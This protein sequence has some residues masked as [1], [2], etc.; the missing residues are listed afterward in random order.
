MNQGEELRF[1]RS[2]GINS[3]S[4]ALNITGTSEVFSDVLGINSDSLVDLSNEDTKIIGVES[5]EVQRGNVKLNG[6]QWNT[7]N[8][9]KAKGDKVKKLIV[10]NTSDIDL[11]KF[12]RSSD[13][14][15]TIEISLTVDQINSDEFEIFSNKF[16]TVNNSKVDIKV[17]G[18]GVIDKQDWP[19]SINFDEGEATF[20]TLSVT[21]D[22][23][24]ETFNLRLLGSFTLDGGL[25][26]DKLVLKAN[27][28]LDK[29]SLSNVEILGQ[30]MYT[31]YFYFFI[32][33]GFILLVAMVGAI[34]LT[35]QA[36][37][38]V[39]RQQIF[40]Q[41]SRNMESAIFLVNDKNNK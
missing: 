39:R 33:A 19:L 30:L 26:N 9:I 23:T 1:S 14:N 25:G 31:Y 5:L 24:D 8:T 11:T 4:G 36:Q 22:E 6:S 10:E 21:G 3:A 29:G 40:Q 32:V 2:A 12:G 35:M 16:N 13:D 20:A 34:I 7:F 15:T 41:V 17:L 18:T 28:S 38:N 27:S 37:A